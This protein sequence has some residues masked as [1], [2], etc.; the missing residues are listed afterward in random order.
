MLTSLSL[1]MTLQGA[2]IY[3][4]V[5]MKKKKHNL[6]H[7]C[8]CGRSKGDLTNVYLHM[9]KKS[10]APRSTQHPVATSEETDGL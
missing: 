7:A 1:S 4:H 3:G 2:C 5:H 10:H 6:L 9:E 8:E